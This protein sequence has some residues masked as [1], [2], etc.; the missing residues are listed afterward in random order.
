MKS[1]IYASPGPHAF[2]I[3]VKIGR[4]SK[5]NVA[6]L[7]MLPELFGDEAQKY[8]MLVFT[9][10]DELGGQ[11]MDQKI[12][13]SSCVSALVS[14]CAGGYCVFDNKERK[15]QR[16]VRDFMK[17][18]NEIVSANEGKH[19][20]SDMFKMAETFIKEA[21]RTGTA[22][23]D[24]EQREAAQRRMQLFVSRRWWRICCCF[25]SC[26][27]SASGSEDEHEALL[28][29]TTD[30]RSCERPVQITGLST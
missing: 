4:M 9:H 11:S 29:V 15:S 19:C 24:Q 17:K 26:C 28:T 14:M 8:T 16:Q 10:G 5:T 18:I 30:Y 25:T 22:G 21:V 6:L 7:E 13:S 1:L 2:V 3:V 27:C 12:Q 23:S 20:T